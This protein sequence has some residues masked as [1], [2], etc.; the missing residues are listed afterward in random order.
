MK[1][2][3]R[4]V[5]GTFLHKIHLLGCFRAPILVYRRS[6]NNVF[7]AKVQWLVRH[8]MLHGRFID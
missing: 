5:K 7:V 2:D 1:F 4:S 6:R 8:A 3:A